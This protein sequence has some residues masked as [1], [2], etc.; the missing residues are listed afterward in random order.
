METLIRQ[1][2]RSGF[3]C[4]NAPCVYGER[5]SDKDKSCRF[6][7]VDHIL[8]DGRTKVHRCGKY[9]EIKDLPGA[10]ITPAFGAGCC[11][12]LFNENRQSIIRLTVNSSHNEN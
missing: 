10:D 5:T 3:C 1:C 11:Q 9:D 7:E 2:V 6:L 8:Q 4:Q 12:P